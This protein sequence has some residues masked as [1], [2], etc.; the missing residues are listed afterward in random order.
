VDAA[1]IIIDY[2]FDNMQQHRVLI[3]DSCFFDIYGFTNDTVK[4][5]F[6]IANK[7]NFAKVLFNFQC[8]Y[9]LQNIVLQLLNDKFAVLDEYRF[10]VLPNTFLLE[11]IKPASYKF[12]IYIDSNNDGFWSPGNIITSEM[13]EQIFLLPK[14]MKLEKGWEYEE[15]WKL[16]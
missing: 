12:R 10:A 11:N 8:E 7:E 16:E 4:I 14:T 3:P 13:P 6:S 1:N 15:D 5:N 2:P 9:D